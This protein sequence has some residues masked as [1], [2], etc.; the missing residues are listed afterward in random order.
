MTSGML[1][2]KVC[3]NGKAMGMVMAITPQLDPV[4]N[5]SSDTVIN[6]TTGN[7]CAVMKGDT[8]SMT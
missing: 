4:V 1:T 5:D 7:N 6:T 8:A 2:S 3:A